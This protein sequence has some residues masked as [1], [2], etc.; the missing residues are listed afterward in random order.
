MAGKVWSALQ[1]RELE[2]GSRVE[3]SWKSKNWLLKRDADDVAW[4]IFDRAGESVNTLSEAVLSELDECLGQLE[5]RPAKGLVLRS[6][7]PSGFIAGADV[8]DFRGLQDAQEV[9]VRLDRAQAIVNRLD[10]LTFPTVAVIHG[11]CLGG[12]LEL[13]LACDYRLALREA[14]F[15]FP[16]IKLGLHPGLGGTAR[17]TRLIDPLDAMTMML[18]GR[19]IS[20][21]KAKALGLVDLVT[22]ERHVLAAARAAVDG[23]IKQSR[24]GLRARALS[25][26]PVRKYA[27]EK[28]RAKT[29]EKARQE[30]YPAPYALIDLWERYGG[31]ADLFQK[32]RESFVDLLVGDTAQNLIRVFFLREKLKKL[33]ANGSELRYVHV[34]GAG[35]MGGDIAAWCALKGLEVSINDRDSHALAKVAK[36]ACDLF[37]RRLEAASER[38]DALDRLVLDFEGRGVDRADI[39]IEAAP[40]RLDVKHEVYRAI[41]PRMR[42]DAVLTTNTSSI[43]LEELRQGLERPERL[44]GLHFFNPVASLELVELVRHNLSSDDALARVRSF[45]GRINRLAAP[46]ASAPGFLV[47]RALTPYLLEALT[48]LDEGAEPETI[49]EAAVRF[50]MPMGPIEVADRVGL[51]ICLEVADKLRQSVNLL[52]EIPAWLRDKVKKGELGFK[53]GKGLYE[54]SA[55]KPKKRDAAPEPDDVMIDRLVLPLVN[56]CVECLRKEIVDDPDLVDAAMIFATG[57]APFRGGPLHYAKTRGAEAVV[58]ALQGLSQKHGSRFAPDEGWAALDASV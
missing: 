49:D 29:R 55:G 52:P 44:V 30:H 51:D 31:G 15:A 50:G 19:S 37:S 45:C 1:G 10:A 28:M 36:R 11:F 24:G 43:P 48:M 56:A 2:M 58:A 5:A 47:N 16:E 41:E 14:S 38:R 21:P 26:A 22:E 39:I 35:V 27:A 53:S 17:L 9:E 46:V 8:A 12:G 42:R 40:E 18:T 3:P 32:E 13:A 25:F 6:A 34:I 23:K 7:K 33:A 20:A 57:F 54:Y 4:L